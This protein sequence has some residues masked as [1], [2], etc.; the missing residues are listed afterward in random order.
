MAAGGCVGRARCGDAQGG[1]FTE[2]R[3]GRRG[4]V[5]G[6]WGTAKA[7]TGPG[8]QRHGCGAEINPEGE[9]G[10]AP[11]GGGAAKG[12]GVGGRAPLGAH[13]AARVG[14]LFAGLLRARPSHHGRSR[15]G[16]RSRVASVGSGGCP[17]LEAGV[18]GDP[19]VLETC[20]GD[21]HS[22]G[23]RCRSHCPVH[24]AR[25]GPAAELRR[26]S[27][28]AGVDEGLAVV[29]A[30]VDG[31]PARPSRDWHMGSKSQMDASMVLWRG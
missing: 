21:S 19:G 5:V 4:R 15:Q 17:R 1:R 16:A 14:Q 9:D 28:A 30:P 12:L 20:C 13:S 24:R 6:R 29:R 27:L 18:G 25:A 2:G 8:L 26:R 23:F 22:T 7:R 31:R 10:D 3:F 11:G